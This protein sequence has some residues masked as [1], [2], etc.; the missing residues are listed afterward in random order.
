MIDEIIKLQ[1]F[2]I[3]ED[4]FFKCIYSIIPIQKIL[5]SAHG[6]TEVIF[7]AVADMEVILFH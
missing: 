4:F 3:T 5:I 6:C 7:E 2:F 1:I